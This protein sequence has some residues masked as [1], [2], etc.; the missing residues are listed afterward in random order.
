M[1]HRISLASIKGL[2]REM[3]KGRDVTTLLE[4]QSILFGS[5]ALATLR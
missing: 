4:L 1:S 3:D 2:I 5:S